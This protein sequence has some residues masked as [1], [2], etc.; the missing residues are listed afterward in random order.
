MLNI[1]VN[2]HNA[3]QQEERLMTWPLVSVAQM[4][5]GFILWRVPQGRGPDGPFPAYK[6]KVRGGSTLIPAALP[7]PEAG[8]LYKTKDGRAAY[9][10][11]ADW[12]IAVAGT[13]NMNFRRSGRLLKGAQVKVMSPTLVRINFKG[14]NIG[15][16]SNAAV[17]GFAQSHTTQSILGLTNAEI[18]KISKHVE[19]TFPARYMDAQKINEMSFK[20]RNKLA[21]AERSL[22]KAKQLFKEARASV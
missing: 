8:L 3:L 22:A 6:K 7:H 15:G 21:A 5:L 18:R 17:A 11:Y 9:T 16:K 13:V 1:D 19:A 4:A 10:S 12:K 20:A 2:F 14:R